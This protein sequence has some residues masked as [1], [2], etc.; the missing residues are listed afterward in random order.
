MKSKQLNGKVVEEF[1][2]VITMEEFL[3]KANMNN[4][5]DLNLLVLTVKRDI[6]NKNNKKVLLSVKNEKED[7]PIGYIS[8]NTINKLIAKYP[9]KEFK[10]GKIKAVTILDVVKNLTKVSIKLDLLVEN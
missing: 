9:G 10:F 7:L 3:H 5:I 8:D 2:Q 6:I 4:N 1:V